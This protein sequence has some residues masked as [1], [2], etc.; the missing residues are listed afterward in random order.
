MAAM[1]R[2]RVTPTRA[3]K[4]I[5]AHYPLFPAQEMLRKRARTGMVH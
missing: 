1:L 5:P 4:F 3:T 2:S